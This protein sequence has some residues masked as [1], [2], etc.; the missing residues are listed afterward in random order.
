VSHVVDACRRG[1]WRRSLVA[2]LGVLATELGIPALAGPFLLA[3]V[4]YVGAGAV[5]SA[6][7]RPDPF[8]V[9]RHLE[10]TSI[11]ND[12]EPRSVEPRSA[13]VATVDEHAGDAA[14]V[15]LTGGA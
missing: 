2:P 15:G 11:T 3:A 4:A 10:R 9:A 1:R 5:L 7:L 12:A 8:L 13:S 6:Q 14:R